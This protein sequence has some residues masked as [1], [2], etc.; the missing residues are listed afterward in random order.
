[1][2]KYLLVISGVLILSAC[3]SNAQNSNLNSAISYF[4]D[5]EKFN[6]QSSLPKAKEKIDLASQN[7]G[8]KDKFKTWHYKGKI[9]LSLFDK[10][11]RDEL[12]KS[13]ETDINKK[14]VTAYLAASMD[15]LD[16]SR[17]AFEKEIELD[18]KKIYSSEAN[19]K[20]KI[21]A[22]NYNDKGYSCIINNKFEDAVLNYQKSYDMKLKMNIVDTAI[23]NNIAVA[24]QE[25]KNYKKAEEYFDKL[26][27]MNYYP[28][29]NY[30]AILQMYNDANDTSSVSR[31]LNKALIAMP[32]N[33]T[34]LIERINVYLKAGKSEAAISSINQAISKNPNNHELH[35]VLGQTYNKMAF[36][37]DASGRDLAKP[38]NY[39]DL[40]KKADAEFNKAIEIKPDYYVGLYSIGIF[41]NNVGA[42]ILKKTDKMKDPKKI[43][44]EEDK[45]DAL[46]IKAVPILERARNIDN[47]DM[48]IKRTLRQLY[49]RTG[50]GDSEK[51]KKLNEE[52]KSSS[53]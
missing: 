14:L 15:M 31:V 30:L 22:S 33:Y 7:D 46:F 24:Y 28:E 27:S 1:M 50:Q 6:D 37:Q 35:L 18:T 16:E 49:V 29:K 20:L 43:K 4:D 53:K 39:D 32:E 13:S 38:N 41:Y 45:A 51:Y 12:N 9:Y 2:K 52:I 3:I 5:F 44:I 19:D 34:F 42:E 21:I 23:I 25:Q 40:I 11:L 48:D 8:T 17:N 36:P 10:Q 26:I 47:T